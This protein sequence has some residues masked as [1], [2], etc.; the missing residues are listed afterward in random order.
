MLDDNKDLSDDNAAA[1]KS[2]QAAGRLFGV[3]SGRQLS[4]V[5][6]ALQGKI[7]PDFVVC[8]NGAYVKSLS[9]QVSWH[10]IPNA[11][12]QTVL[13]TMNQLQPDRIT[14][15]ASGQSRELQPGELTKLLIQLNQGEPVFEKLSAVYF[16]HLEQLE[17]LMT[18]LQQLAVEVTRSDVNF[19]EITAK[20]VSKLSGLKLALQDRYTL[21]Q[22]A[23]IGDYGNDL[24]IIANVAVGAA[25]QNATQALKDQAAYIAVDHNHSAIANLIT[26][27]LHEENK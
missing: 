12:T 19:L 9:G 23:A 17:N 22:V 24:A 3:T 26:H 13:K 16:E 4:G 25:V 5:D 21:D 10:R 14:L 8:L 20:D 1:V 6:R 11:V 7:Q 2:W 18:K 27:I 15:T